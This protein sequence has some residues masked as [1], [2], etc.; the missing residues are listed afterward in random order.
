M[1]AKITARTRPSTVVTMLPAAPARRRVKL[2]SWGPYSFAKAGR[3]LD[4]WVQT[5]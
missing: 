5:A 2:A 1:E 4:A 3:L